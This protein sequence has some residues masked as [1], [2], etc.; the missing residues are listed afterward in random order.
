[1]AI[2]KRIASFALGL[3]MLG[4]IGWG[5]VVLVQSIWRALIE[6]NPTVAAAI[7]AGAT[8]I[9]VSVASVLVAKH[10]EQRNNIRKELRDK[11]AP[12]YEELI[13]FVF[14]ILYS[15]KMKLPAMSEAEIVAKFGG[16]T[17]KLIIWGSDDVVHAL[18]KFRRF[19]NLEDKSS[20]LTIM[21]VEEM[22]L[23]IRRDLGHANKNLGPGKILGTFV[24][25]VHKLFES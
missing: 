19:S 5:L 13:E 21:A 22:F 15:E 12:V 11:K 16:I 9:V 20:A 10:L 4:G 25:D 2:V 3:V 8:T 1:V 23:A 14:L 18:Y 7:L 6:V 17:R 24:N